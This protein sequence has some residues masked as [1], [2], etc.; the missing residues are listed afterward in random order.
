MWLLLFL[1]PKYFSTTSNTLKQRACYTIW[2]NDHTKIKTLMP[3]NYTQQV[4]KTLMKNVRIFKGKNVRKSSSKKFQRIIGPA[5]EFKNVRKMSRSNLMTFLNSV[6][7]C[8]IFEHF[9]W[10]FMIRSNCMALLDLGY[11]F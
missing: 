7:F 11:Y 6:R 9:F 3:G 1:A 5:L 8:D 2:H 10:H 4:I